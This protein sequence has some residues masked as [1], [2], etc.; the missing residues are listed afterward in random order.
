MIE[1][2]WLEPE[3]LEQVVFG[4]CPMD[5]AVLTDLHKCPDCGNDYSKIIR[6]LNEV[7]VKELKLSGLKDDTIKYWLK[8]GKETK[9]EVARII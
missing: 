2:D 8:Y 7:P 5:G 3:Q 1:K 6:W 9:N 4:A